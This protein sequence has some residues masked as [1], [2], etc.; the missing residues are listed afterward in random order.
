MRHSGD[1]DDYGLPHVDIVVPDDAREL[2]P[3]IVAYRREER[4]RRRQRRWRRVASPLTRY[5]L[6]APIIAGAL[7]IALISGTVI[8]VFGPNPVPR[9][10]GAPVAQRPTAARGK[11][12]GVLPEGQVDVPGHRK[13]LIDLRPAVLMI[14]PPGCRCETTIDE[15]SR[16][17]NDYRIGLY[18]VADRRDAEETVQQSAKEMRKLAGAARHAVA[19]V[20]RDEDAVL[21]TTYQAAGLTAVF[22]HADGVV[23]DVMKNLQP[24]LHLEKRLQRLQN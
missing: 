10:T 7:L 16:Q 3:D 6:A 24:G 12:G 17:T 2:D 22:V 11:I 14:V 15:M 23:D 20:A 13:Q 8:T 21:A 19:I 5:G 18:L 4:R 1:P 9:A